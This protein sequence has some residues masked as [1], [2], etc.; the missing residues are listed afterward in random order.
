MRLAIVLG[1]ERVIYMNFY[2]VFNRIYNVL[3][4]LSIASIVIF[5]V[6]Y[7][8]KRNTSG[9][10]ILIAQIVIMVVFILAH[11][12]S[13]ISEILL[14]FKNDIDNFSD[15]REKKLDLYNKIARSGFGMFSVLAYLMDILKSNQLFII[16]AI[17][18]IISL[19]LSFIFWYNKRVLISQKN[20]EGTL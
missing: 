18:A 14:H 19:L 4:Y 16:F 13:L 9:D 20:S 1:M 15:K 3:Y 7:A 5:S 11:V 12:M 2:N 8:N 6:I 17:F 10:K